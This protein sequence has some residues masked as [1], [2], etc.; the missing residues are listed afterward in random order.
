MNVN[1][2]EEN[3]EQSREEEVRAYRAQSDAVSR[4]STLT[5][6]MYQHV[7]IIPRIKRKRKIRAS[8]RAIQIGETIAEIGVLLWAIEQAQREAEDLGWKEPKPY[9]MFTCLGL[10]GRDLAETLEIIEKAK[11]RRE[12]S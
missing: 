11:A 6:I 7:A 12:T 2:I 4:L 8:I 9:H 10:E 5:S 3:T 1:A